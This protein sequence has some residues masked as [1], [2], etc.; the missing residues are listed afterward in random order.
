MHTHKTINCT[1]KVLGKETL[2][3]LETHLQILMWI[4][5]NTVRQIDVIE[6]KVNNFGCTLESH[7]KSFKILV[8]GSYIFLYNWWGRETFKKLLR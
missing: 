8:P 4:Y 1:A 2:A 6:K 3:E 5:G 7:G